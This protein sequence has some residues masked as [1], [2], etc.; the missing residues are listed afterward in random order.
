[1]TNDVRRVA[2]LDRFAPEGVRLSEVVRH[3]VIREDRLRV[4]LVEMNADIAPP[5]G[6][7]G[8]AMTGSTDGE[9]RPR[10]R[11]GPCA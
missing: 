10:R 2:V 4:G 5:T 9:F 8:A 7:G 3:G 6:R 1:M 11:S